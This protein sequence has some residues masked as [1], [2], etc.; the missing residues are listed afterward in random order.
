MPARVAE[1]IIVSALAVGLNEDFYK[2]AL[3]EHRSKLLISE[4]VYD[5]ELLQ[6]PLEPTPA[7]IFIGNAPEGASALEVVTLLRGQYPQAAIFFVG[8]SEVGCDRK[9]LLDKGCNEAFLLPLDQQTLNHAVTDAIMNAAGKGAVFRSIKLIDISPDTRLDFDTYVFLQLNNKHIKFSVAGN[10]LEKERSDRLREHDVGSL[11]VSVDQMAKFY[12]YTAARLQLIQGDATLSQTERSD[13]LERAV[14]GLVGD[15]FSDQASSLEDAERIV[16]DCHNVVRTYIT[17]TAS[18]TLY[19]KILTVND[20]SSDTYS[21]AANVSTYAGLFAIALGVAC[22]DE[23][24]LAA[25]LH[26][27]GLAHVKDEVLEPHPEMALEIIRKRKLVLSPL[28][29]TIILQ[30]HERFD[31]AGYPNALSGAEICVAAQILSLADRIDE[32]A[33]PQAGHARVTPL[34]AVELLRKQIAEDPEHAAFDAG[35]LEKVWTL[36]QG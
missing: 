1:R 13:R 35:L 11:Y 18:G 8:T 3:V 30:H 24:A 15:I 21:H 4:C 29:E 10:V 25:L 12:E 27:I 23:I 28:V 33:A 32:L 20:T 9:M 17:N 7:L 19:E 31:G 22:V 34:Q 5:L 14:R 16:S 6:T 36:F 26:D 2:I